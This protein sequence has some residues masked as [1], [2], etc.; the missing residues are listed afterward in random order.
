MLE[1]TQNY[2]FILAS[3]H[4][5]TEIVEYF[6]TSHTDDAT[7]LNHVKLHAWILPCQVFYLF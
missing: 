1:D 4:E 5:V 7:L 2:I 3:S 6:T